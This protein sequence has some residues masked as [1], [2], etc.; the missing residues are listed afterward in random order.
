MK[1]GVVTGSLG[2]LGF[3]F[4]TIIKL[5]DIKRLELLRLYFFLVTQMVLMSTYASSH[6]RLKIV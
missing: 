5:M 6:G 1:D 3:C 2:T 4:R